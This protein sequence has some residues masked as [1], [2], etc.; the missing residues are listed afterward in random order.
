MATTR[1]LLGAASKAVQPKSSPFHLPFSPQ[2]EPLQLRKQDEL[3]ILS[4]EIQFM[5]MQAREHYVALGAEDIYKHVYQVLRAAVRGKLILPSTN[6]A[7][8]FSKQVA[9][10]ILYHSLDSV[11]HIPNQPFI[12]GFE[13]RFLLQN[14][15]KKLDSC[16]G[17][18]SNAYNQLLNDCSIDLTDLLVVLYARIAD[19]MAMHLPGTVKAASTKMP[20]IFPMH[21][22]WEEVKKSWAWPMLNIYCPIADWGS[23]TTAYREMRDNAVAYLYPREVAQLSG[24]VRGL[25][26]ALQNTGKILDSVLSD[27]STTLGIRVLVADDN[28][29]MS[30]GLSQLDDRTVIVRKRPFKGEGGLIYKAI[31]KDIS[32][33]MVHDWAGATIITEN[34]D[35]LYKVVSYLYAGG[36][37][38]A[39]RANGVRDLLTLP[40]VDYVSSPK[41]VTLYQ[42]IHID[43]VSR[44]PRMVPLEI[45]VRTAAMHR[46][47]DIGTA[48]HEVYKLCPLHNG[49]RARFMQRLAEIQSIVQPYACRMPFQLVSGIYMPLGADQTGNRLAA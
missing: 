29:S 6:G 3:S 49:E 21:N 8:P 22:D 2:V 28:D 26:P 47:A 36:I 33:D 35:L 9:E 42:S 34:E 19:M 14:R 44:D 40:P 20:G 45:I 48:G 16:S 46:N 37:Q 4:P 7:D 32:V 31:K 11:S 1:Y 12:P 13:K 43:T 38:S 10:L 27:M 15:F 23:L 18:R 5:A 30:A 24:R 25:M 39:A 41:P 17:E